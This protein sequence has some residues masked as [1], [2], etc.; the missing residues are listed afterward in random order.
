MPQPSKQTP[1]LP[2]AALGFRHGLNGT[3][4]ARTM[5][6]SELDTLLQ[7]ARDDAS[8]ASIRSRILE[9]NALN[10][11]TAK[12][13]QLT[14]RH[15]TSLYGLDP[16]IPTWRVFR[17]LWDA[18]PDSRPL[19][20][21]TLALARDPLLRLS[22]DYIL[23][24]SIDTV[25]TRQDMEAVLST[26]LADRVSA[27]SLQSYARNI[28]SSWTQA[29]YLRGLTQKTRQHPVVT[30]TN[31]AFALFL[32]YLE[33]A[34]GQR[35]FTSQWAALL[36]QPLEALHQLARIAAQ[37]DL[38]IYRRAGNVTEVRFP[39]YLSPAETQRLPA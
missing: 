3:H 4:A 22:Q 25:I 33:G 36:D 15:L 18:D 21:L 39:D 23:S 34:S 30:P 26:P 14:L 9:H 13:R 32:A 38:L 29:G 35:L 8:L 10:K 19:L 11:P 20:A 31:L 16:R 24:L 5:M 17:S 7:T 28:N 27:S 1:H 37:R 12:A 2:P 6:L